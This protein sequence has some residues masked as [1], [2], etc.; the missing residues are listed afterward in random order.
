MRSTILNRAKIG[1][2]CIIGACALVTEGMEIP[3]YSM[4][5]GVP[6]KIV[7]QLPAA[8][9]EKLKL[10]AAHYVK[11]AERHQSGEFKPIF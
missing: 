4:V 7:K 6:A 2:H 5:L 1:K 11:M 8:Y 9:A 10:S 3:D